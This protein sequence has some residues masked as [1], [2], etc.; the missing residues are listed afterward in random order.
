MKQ[1]LRIKRCY[2]TSEKAVESQIWIA[3]SV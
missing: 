2:G 3:V 1:N